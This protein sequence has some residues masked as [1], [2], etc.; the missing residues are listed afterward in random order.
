V[1]KAA[2][3]AAV[4]MALLGVQA[5]GGTSLGGHTGKLLGAHEASA[6]DN[7]MP[8]DW[9]DGGCGDG[10]TGGAGDGGTGG[11]GDGGTWIPTPT[12]PC[13]Y[14]SAACGPTDGGC[15]SFRVCPLPDGGSRWDTVWP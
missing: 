13:P 2:V 11:A 4:V 9:L 15:P 8:C 1:V 6:A 10:G 12:D 3:V 5:I 14:L 7:S